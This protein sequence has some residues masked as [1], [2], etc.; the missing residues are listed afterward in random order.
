MGGNSN[1]QDE[2]AEDPQ[3]VRAMAMA[4]D[5]DR[6][7]T[8]AASARELANKVRSLTAAA[9]ALAAMREGNLKK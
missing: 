8:L 9:S 5:W 7:A 1:S 6:I 3:L 2:D 4:G